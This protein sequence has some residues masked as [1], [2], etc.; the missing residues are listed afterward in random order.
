MQNLWIFVLQAV[1]G[2]IACSL[3]ETYQSRVN[4]TNS[5][6]PSR[7]PL[8]ID[9]VQERRKDRARS[10]SPTNKSRKTL[11]E[12]DDVVAN[13][14]DIGIPSSSR[15]VDTASSADVLVVVASVGLV[16][17]RGSGKVVGD[18]CLLV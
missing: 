5:R 15:I 2:H 7:D 8:L 4:K 16:W 9:P 12:D 11:I 3:R 18:C 10:R 6:L 17:W 1:S 13:S 14:A